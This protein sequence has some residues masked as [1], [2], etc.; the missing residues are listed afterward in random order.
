MKLFLVNGEKMNYI[1]TQENK[2]IRIETFLLC[3]YLIISFVPFLYRTFTYISLVLI[4]VLLVLNLQVLM[5]RPYVYSL[6]GI[7]IITFWE[8]LFYFTGKSSTELGYIFYPFKFFTSV[9]IFLPISEKITEK[10]KRIILYSWFLGYLITIISN[11]FSYFSLGELYYS[12]QTNTELSNSNIAETYY[13]T[14]VIICMCASLVLLLKRKKFP[15][16]VRTI[17][18][19]AFIL[20]LAFTIISLRATNIIITA[21]TLLL[22]LLLNNKSKRAT[23]IIILAAIV[24]FIA[25]MFFGLGVKILEF[26]NSF[27]IS[28]R[29]K[30]RLYSIIYV[31]KTWDFSGSRSSLSGRYKY[32][33]NSYNTWTANLSNFLFGVGDQRDSLDLV[34]NHSY[35]LDTLARFGVFYFLI[36][37]YLLFSSCKIVMKK[38][39]NNNLRLLYLI[40]IIAFVIRNILG[41]SIYGVVGFSLTCTYPLLMS[42]YQK[43]IILQ[44]ESNIHEW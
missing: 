22:I 30:D 10:E 27:G 1:S 32:T 21:F 16:N 19:L 17:A 41:N 9:L 2:S 20:S 15:S 11:I 42:F 12:F 25:F 26:V 44:Q 34:G 43:K 5:K 7:I 33:M 4:L 37:L 23:R 28:N 31:L 13:G 8:L 24:F 38:L 35:F 39:A 3:I 29:I 18:F 14:A 40:V 36:V 6:I